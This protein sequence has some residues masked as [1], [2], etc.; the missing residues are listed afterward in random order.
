MHL[1]EVY[2]LGTTVAYDRAYT[3][4]LPEDLVEKASAGTLAVVPFGKSN[5]KQS[6][7]ITKL[8]QAEDG[9]EVKGLKPIYALPDYSLAA[10]EEMMALAA[11][12]RDRCFCTYGAA[13]K[14]MLPGGINTKSKVY[15][16]PQPSD[17]D[18]EL[19]RFV[20]S[21]EKAYE[22][23][24][25]ASFGAEGLGR[26]MALCRR[27]LLLRHS[28][29]AEHSNIKTEPWAKLLDPKVELKGA[30]QQLL[31]KLL[32]TGDQSLKA[33]ADQGVSTATVR[34]LCGKGVVAI[35]QKRVQRLA[36]TA[37]AYEE[38]PYTLSEKQRAVKDSIVG[39]MQSGKAEACLLHGVTGSGKTKIILEAVDEALRQGRSA[40]VLMP[41]IGLTAQA[42]STY[43]ARYGNSCGVLHSKL[44]EGERADTYNRVQ[45]GD[46]KVIIGTRSAVFAP[47]ENLGL[48]VLDE[49][50]EHT[51][52]SEKTPKYHARDI[53]RFRCARHGALM[54]LASATPSVESYF[55]AQSGVYHLL[56]LDER[57]GGIELPSVEIVDIVGDER[58]D[59]GKLIGTQ[60]KEALEH[61]LA[62][63]EQAILFLGRRGYN[64]ALRCRS[65]GYVFTCSRCSVSLNYHAYSNDPGRRGKLICHYCG[66]VEDKPHKCPEC[67]NTHIGY[68]GYGTQL[69]QDE[70]EEL[71]GE[72]AALR[73]D[74]DTTG[75]KRSHDEILEEFGRGDAQILYGTQMIVKGLDFSK[76]SL[77]G[78]VMADS[79]LYMSDFRAP[80]RMFSLIT[81]LVGRAGRAGKQGRAIVQTYNPRHQTLRLGAKQDYTAF[82]SSEIRLRKAVVFPP[83]CDIA[84]FSFSSMDEGAVNKTAAR[85]SADF[86]KAA[87]EMGG[88]KLIKMGPFK[89]GIYKIG[90]RYRNKIIVKYRDSKECRALFRSLMAQYSVLGKEDAAV[91]IDINP[92]TV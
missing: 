62:K 67:G 52:K 20:V 34:N 21:K 83:F 88:I 60:L 38:K 75:A 65:C 43:F 31:I 44:S 9:Q 64:S 45:S 78:L 85:F 41:E 46:I 5:R 4:I 87:E 69:L 6:A 55:K 13:L 73:M 53:A 49:E 84:V 24:I 77:V 33:L 79:V 27:G 17:S 26:A 70:L 50:Q 7:F 29:V 11:F 23:D 59:T 80:E 92:F 82:Y 36:Y 40:I 71:F 58:I 1:C 12:V 91:D 35:Y 74:T 42:V 57:Y 37:E 90:G 30:K 3:Y 68:F 51:Y 15:Y 66:K 28:E 25:K 56:S 89:E 48:I 76:V 72:G 19:Y 2:L 8:W 86:E 54:L 47:F 16:T 39:Y 61:T 32:A 14:L 18:D 63:G 22:K 81:Q 10:T